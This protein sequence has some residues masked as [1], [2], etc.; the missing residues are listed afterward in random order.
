MFV[1]LPVPDN[2]MSDIISQRLPVEFTTEQIRKLN[3]PTPLEMIKEVQKGGGKY[4]YVPHSYITEKLNEIFQHRWTFEV[5]EWKVWEVATKIIKTK[6]TGDQTEYTEEIIMVPDQV[7]VIGRLQVML[8]D[9]IVIRKEQVGTAH[10]KRY[11]AD[12]ATRPNMAID[13]GNDIKS[14][15][16]DAKKKCASELGM[17]LDVYAPILDEYYNAEEKR[18]TVEDMEHLLHSI[19]LCATQEELTKIKPEIAEAM[20]DMDGAQRTATMDHC[21]NKAKTFTKAK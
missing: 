8:G 5:K 11:R 10:V 4:K 7:T 17:C 1:L 16:S 15:A 12:H 19:D 2:P 3:Q 13:I 21:I 6:K 9:G 14:A 20:R 18:S